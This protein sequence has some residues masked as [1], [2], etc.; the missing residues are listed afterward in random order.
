MSNGVNFGNLSSVAQSG[1][2]SICVVLGIIMMIMSYT[3]QGINTRIGADGWI[4]VEIGIGLF[5]I[6]IVIHIIIQ[7]VS[8]K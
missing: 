8:K 1:V 4:I 3:I 6:Q 7:L 5:L 2:P